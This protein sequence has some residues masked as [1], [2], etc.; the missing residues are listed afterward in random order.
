MN[1]LSNFSGGAGYSMVGVRYLQLSVELLVPRQT[2]FGEEE[3]ATNI[4]I[5]AGIST[6]NVPLFKVVQCTII[7]KKNVASDTRPEVVTLKYE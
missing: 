5:S 1:Q 6:I 2:L 7:Y 3:I 4:F